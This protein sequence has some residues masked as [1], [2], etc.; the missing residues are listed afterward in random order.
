[1]REGTCGG[2]ASVF[3]VT[4]GWILTSI[5]QTSELDMLHH[6]YYPME[7][8]PTYR[9]VPFHYYCMHFSYW[10]LITYANLIYGFFLSPVSSVSFRTNFFLHS[11]VK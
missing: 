8:E 5:T 6:L 3:S 1:M 2:L 9:I 10:R 4:T 7:I 11:C